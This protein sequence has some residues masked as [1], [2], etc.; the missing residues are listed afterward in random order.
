MLCLN[1]ERLTPLCPFCHRG[2]ETETGEWL[3]R[4]PFQPPSPLPPSTAELGRE[5]PEFPP[6]LQLGLAT[7]S[8]HETQT[9]VSGKDVPSQLKGKLP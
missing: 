8:N 6:P 7:R 9:E 4:Y 2:N 1:H 3:P 5:V